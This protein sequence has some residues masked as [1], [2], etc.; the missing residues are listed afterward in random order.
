MPQLQENEKEEEEK[1]NSTTRKQHRR[2]VK[3]MENSMQGGGGGGGQAIS[4]FGNGFSTIGPWNRDLGAIL[5]GKYSVF[6]LVY[7]IR[8]PFFFCSHAR[9]ALDTRLFWVKN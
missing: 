7:I 4:L 1:K 3:K 2:M 9:S 8:I 6:S 5:Q